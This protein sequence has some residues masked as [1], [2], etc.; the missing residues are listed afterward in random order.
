MNFI[1]FYNSI[2]YDLRQASEYDDFGETDS[3]KP[4]SKKQAQ[5]II[6]EQIIS[7]ATQAAYNY[8][9]Y[10]IIE[11]TVTAP[12][13][14]IDFGDSVLIVHA[15][16]RGRAWELLAD[17]YERN[18]VITAIAP[19]TIQNALGWKAGDILEFRVT[20]TPTPIANETDLVDFPTNNLELLRKAIVVEVSGILGF[21][22]RQAYY[23]KYGALMQE[24]KNRVKMKTRKVLTRRTYGAIGFRGK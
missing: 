2:E 19:N 15:I 14:L 18:A 16:K 23:T 13:S 21:E 8:Q 17:A 5:R 6:N 22:I 9:R 12:T 7:L 10:T 1:D 24:W 3:S 11:H 20:L 4:L